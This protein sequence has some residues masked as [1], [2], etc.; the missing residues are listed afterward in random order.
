[1]TSSDVLIIGA[2]AAGSA[3]AFHLAAKGHRVVLLEERDR[4]RIKPCGGG[5]AASV[6]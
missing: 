6:Q 5:M 2:G 3:A 1:M 4:A